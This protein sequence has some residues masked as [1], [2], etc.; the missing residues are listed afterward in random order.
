MVFYKLKYETNT[1]CTLI[2]YSLAKEHEFMIDA[3][4]TKDDM[5]VLL[6]TL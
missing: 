5:R 4:V 1:R 2:Y 3:S 6:N